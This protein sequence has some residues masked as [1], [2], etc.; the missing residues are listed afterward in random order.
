MIERRSEGAVTSKET[1]VRNTYLN[2]GAR[3]LDDHVSVRLDHSEGGDGLD[4]VLL[5][6]LAERGFRLGSK[7]EHEK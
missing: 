5:E 4:V 3:I 1:P 2:L 6:Q 7:A